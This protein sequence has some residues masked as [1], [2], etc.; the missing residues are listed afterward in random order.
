MKTKI[1]KNVARNIK[2]SVGRKKDELEKA[3]RTAGEEAKRNKEYAAIVEERWQTLRKE[4]MESAKKNLVSLNEFIRKEPLKSYL[5]LEKTTG[6]PLW[7]GSGTYPHAKLFLRN[8]GI[9]IWVG[10]PKTYESIKKITL[11]S[12]ATHAQDRSNLPSYIWSLSLE[13][14]N[15]SNFVEYLRKQF[16]P[17]R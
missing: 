2:A 14:W 13:K 3:T 1:P 9:Y 7:E 6:F 12:L 16:T 17:I 5:D 4:M 10:Y 15:A 11:N 8:D